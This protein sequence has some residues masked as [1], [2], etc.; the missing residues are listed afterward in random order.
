VKLKVFVCLVGADS[1]IGVVLLLRGAKRTGVG[2]LAEKASLGTLYEGLMSK[3][4][5]GAVFGNRGL[6]SGRAT[7]GWEAR[8]LI[9][10]PLACSI[11]CFEIT[12]A[13]LVIKPAFLSVGIGL[14]V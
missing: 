8:R 4:S 13:G 11:L 5:E 12:G 7:A 10:G 3:S 1:G 2:P 6:I 9:P 14:G